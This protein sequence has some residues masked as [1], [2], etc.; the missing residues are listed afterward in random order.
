MVASVFAMVTD[1]QRSVIVRRNVQ[2]SFTFCINQHS[3]GSI[4]CY[5]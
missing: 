2:V 5:Q 1:F 3:T 4:I